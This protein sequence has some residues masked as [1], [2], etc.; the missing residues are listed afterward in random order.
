M[1]AGEVTE[2][3]IEQGKKKDLQPPDPAKNKCYS[4]I[5]HNVFA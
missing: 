4:I 5:P 3:L 2:P 1:C